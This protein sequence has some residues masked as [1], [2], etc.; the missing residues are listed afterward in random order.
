M[1]SLELFTGGGGLA[2]GLSKAGFHHS[3]F[4]EF[5]SYSCDSLRKNFP[6]KIVHQVDAREF[7]F[8]EIKGITLVA[9]GP[10]CQPFSNGGKHRAYDDSRDMFPTAI[11]A[12]EALKPKAFLFENVKGLLRPSFSEY[13]DYVIA[14]L[15]SPDIGKKKSEDWWRHLLRLKKINSDKVLG[16]TYHVAYKL[17]NSANYGVPQIRHRVFI[18]GFRNDLN[19][20]WA[21]PEPTHS[22]QALERSMHVTNEYWDSHGL[23]PSLYVAGGQQ[24]YGRF[25]QS[26][27][28]ENHLQPWRTVRDA[29]GHLP[30]SR[31]QHGLFDHL[32]RP[33]AK[34]YPGHTGSEIDAPAKTLKAGV[35]GVPGG[36][37]MIR[38]Q[39]GV[40]RWFTVHEA[41]L[42]QTFPEDFSFVGPWSEAMRQIGNAVPVRLAEVLGEQILRALPRRSR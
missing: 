2:Y 28:L 36:E 10:P 12:I 39:D 11:R 40:V 5:D 37:N 14:R 4:V 8:E 21:F 32:Y 35:H 30:D 31:E 3:G 26:S 20:Q 18:V 9:G 24:G 27:L 1:N 6:N 23:N 19:I 25:A 41:K 42:L 16:P 38:Y 13:F 29:I 34:S 15:E 22:K 7:A 33:G 17:L